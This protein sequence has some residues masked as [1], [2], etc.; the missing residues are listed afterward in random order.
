MQKFGRV[1]SL[2]VEVNPQT[3]VVPLRPGTPRGVTIQLPYQIE[4]EI[5]RRTLTSAQTGTF[6]ILNLGP[7]IR[8]AIQKD[9]FQFTELRTIQFRAGYESPDGSF[10]PLA[11]NGNVL[12]AYSYRVDRDWITE[13]EAFDGGWQMANASNVAITLSP[14]TTAAQVIT[15]L[16]NQMEGMSGEPIVGNFPSKNLRGEVLMGNAWT[17]LIQKTAG[18]VTIDNGQVKALGYNEVIQGD[19]LELSAE[20]GLLGSPKRTTSTLEFDMI[21]EPRLTVAQIVTLKSLSQPQLNRPWKV[22]GFDHRGTIS[23]D[24]AGDCL[25]SVRLWFT[26]QD[27]KLIGGTPVQ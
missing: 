1:Y 10:M 17:L 11:F 3:F 13:I 22:I 26:T 15:Q 4:F 9:V 18:N 20:S 19:I 25:T 6:R 12:T 2:S 7:E 24:T 23:P 8:S 27:L 16:A 5:S 14:N 21:F